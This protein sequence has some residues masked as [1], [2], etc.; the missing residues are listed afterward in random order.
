MSH[1]QLEAYL[2]DLIVEE[3][4]K[5]GYQKE[6]IRLYDPLESLQHF[7]HCSDDADVMLRRLSDFPDTVAG[8]LGAVEIS[9]VGDRFCFLIPESGAEYVHTHKKANAFI[10]QLIALI[11][12]HASLEDVKQLFEA[13]PQQVEMRQMTDG[14][15]D[16]VIRFLE[17]EDPYYYC[18]KDEGCHV[19]Y[20][21]FLP[22]DYEA[23]G[24]L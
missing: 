4:A 2:I 11:G 1:K 5:L 17:G 21:R 6:K 9:H 15:F 12:S 16:L 24:I 20:H 7:Y 19:I 3:Q 18:F 10:E 8:T 14:E 22:S 23:F 13:Q